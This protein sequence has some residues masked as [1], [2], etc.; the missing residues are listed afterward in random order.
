M[1]LVVKPSQAKAVMLA[2]SN[3]AMPM[4]NTQP[5]CLRRELSGETMK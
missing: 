3:M 1:P 5:P 4:L 2:R